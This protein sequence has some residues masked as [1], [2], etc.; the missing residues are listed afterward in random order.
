VSK[1]GVGKCL[2]L[3]VGKLGE[4]I[5]SGEDHVIFTDIGFQYGEISSKFLDHVFPQLRFVDTLVAL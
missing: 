4:A 5:Q 3:L 2:Q 1:A